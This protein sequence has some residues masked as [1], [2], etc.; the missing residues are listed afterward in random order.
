MLPHCTEW[1]VHTPSRAVKAVAVLLTV[2]SRT[3]TRTALQ[4]QAS[5]PGDPVA[6]RCNQRNDHRAAVPAASPTT[7]TLTVLASALVVV[8]RRAV[9]L[10]RLPHCLQAVAARSASSMG[11]LTTAAPAVAAGACLRLEAQRVCRPPLRHRVV[12]RRHDRCRQHQHPRRLR[13]A[14]RGMLLRCCRAVVAALSPVR[15]MAAMCPRSAAPV[16]ASPPADRHLC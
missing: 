8:C 9:V 4:R 13:Q 16:L 1:R 11:L 3:M 2:A 5:C 15:V 6:R 7:M 12:V 14:L 10:V